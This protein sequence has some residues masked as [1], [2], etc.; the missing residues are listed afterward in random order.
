[1]IPKLYDKDETEFTSNGMG[2]LPDAISCSVEEEINSIYELALEYPTN[3]VH[4]GEL[5][6][7][8]IIVAAH[9]SGGDWEPFRIYH[10]A[11]TISGTFTVRARHISYDLTRIPVM[12]FSARWPI[13]A[14]QALAD[15]AAIAC[16][17]EFNFNPDGSLNPVTTKLYW[18]QE[19]ETIRS[20]LLGGKNKRLG[21]MADYWGCEFHF[22]K[23]TVDVIKRRGADKNISIRYG[24]NMTGLEVVFEDREGFNAVLP[25]YYEEGPVGTGLDVFVTCDPPVVML[26]DTV[27][28]LGGAMVLDL[29]DQFETAPT[30]QALEN[31]TLQWLLENQPWVTER[32]INIS[33]VELGKT[34]EYQD[35]QQVQDLVLGDSVMVYP[36]HTAERLVYGAR[37][38]LVRVVYDVLRERYTETTLGR[39]PETVASIVANINRGLQKTASTA[40][41]KARHA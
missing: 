36:G 6:E 2:G 34:K 24:V 31:F 1:M 41:W 18:V 15:N 33:F 10:R 4:A 39:N 7:G 32:T 38:R 40:N 8:N 9:D 19:P 11:D 16:P 25:Y 27:D 21:S 23:R 22:S 30:A 3:G 17:F 20:V 35:L 12:P 37:F 5:V 29:S 28:T 26:P 14:V 13:Q